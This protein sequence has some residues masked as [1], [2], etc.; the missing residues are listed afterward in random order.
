[1]IPFD[2]TVKVSLLQ[3]TTTF[4]ASYAL[5]APTYPLRSGNSP[6]SAPQ[7]TGSAASVVEAAVVVVSAALVVVLATVVLVE[8]VLVVEV[9]AVVVVRRAAFFTWLWEEESDPQADTS[10]IPERTRQ[11]SIRFCIPPLCMVCT[12]N[13]THP[14]RFLPAAG[15]GPKGV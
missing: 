3:V 11:E 9:L 5:P 12:S 13:A 14:G 2:F 1:M 4:G 15:P 10:T 8:V 6:L 7:I